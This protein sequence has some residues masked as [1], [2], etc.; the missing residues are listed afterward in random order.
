MKL[1]LP[2]TLT[3]PSRDEA[4]KHFDIDAA[5]ARRAAARIEPGYVVSAGAADKPFAFYARCNVDTDRLWDAFEAFA[6]DLPDVVGTILGCKDAK[7]QLLPYSARAGVVAHLRV[8][9]RELTRD[10]F[11][12]YGLIHQVDGR[13]EEVFVPAAKYVRLWGND[14]VRFRATAARLGLDEIADLRFV[15]EFP[16][17]SHSLHF[18]EPEALPFTEVLEDL[19]DRLDALATMT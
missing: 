8:Y 16:L 13:T 11:L 5:D 14:L 2:S 7:P 12:E 9:R 18:L 15:D 17:I 1:K 6:G 19:R 3:F 4:P 10:P